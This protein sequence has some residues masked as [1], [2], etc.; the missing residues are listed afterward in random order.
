VLYQVANSQEVGTL[1]P[2][3]C[4][5]SGCLLSGSRYSTPVVL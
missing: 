1:S 5:V 3:C 2:L 4:I